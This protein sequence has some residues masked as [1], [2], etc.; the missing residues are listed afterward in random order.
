MSWFRFGLM[1]Y[2]NRLG[3]D[4]GSVFGTFADLDRVVGDYACLVSCLPK[5]SR[6]CEGQHEACALRSHVGALNRDE[7]IVL[8]VGYYLYAT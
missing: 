8:M 6:F 5:R 1:C 2:N 4:F 7:D 3:L